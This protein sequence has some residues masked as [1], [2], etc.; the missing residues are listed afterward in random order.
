MGRMLEREGCEVARSDSY[1]RGY[2]S[3]GSLMHP[4]IPLACTK[5]DK[6][7]HN[8]ICKC[9]KGKNITAFSTSS[10]LL[11]T[12]RVPIPCQTPLP[13]H[14]CR[15]NGEHSV[16]MCSMSP[17]SADS[18]IPSAPRT[19]NAPSCKLLL[20]K[21]VGMHSSWPISHFGTVLVQVSGCVQG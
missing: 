3:P 6:A 8:S 14:H 4:N 12:C 20:P 2:V 5:V 11:S 15:L 17:S 7:T 21:R 13:R 9:R 16:S 1:I 18:A 19:R 10:K